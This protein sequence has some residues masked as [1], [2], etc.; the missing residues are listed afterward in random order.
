MRPIYVRQNR[1]VRGTVA[2]T[3]DAVEHRLGHLPH[4]KFKGESADD[5]HGGS[6]WLVAVQAK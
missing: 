2:R 4:D 5:N 1:L 6:Y 3:R